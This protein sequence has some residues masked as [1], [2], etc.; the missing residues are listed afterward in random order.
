MLVDSFYFKFFLNCS[1]SFNNFQAAIGEDVV[2]VTLVAR[3]CTRR[4]GIQSPCYLFILLICISVC[5]FMVI[6]TVFTKTSLVLYSIQKNSRKLVIPTD[7][8]SL[9]A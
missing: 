6:I 1:S 4:N 2:D 5:S 9:S 3:R 7:L 8:I